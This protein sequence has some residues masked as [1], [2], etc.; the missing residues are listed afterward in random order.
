VEA[1]TFS[2]VAGSFGPVA[3]TAWITA[4]DDTRGRPFIIVDKLSARVLV[5]DGAGG[6][7][8]ETAALIGVAIRDDSPPG[9]GMMRLADIAPALR[10]TPA[11]RFEAHLGQNLKG[12]GIL[13][14]DYE[15][16]L[17]LHPVATGNPAE[18]RLQRLTTGDIADNRITYGCI[19]VPSRFYEDVVQPL[20]APA[21][22]IVYILPELSS[23]SGGRQSIE[24]PQE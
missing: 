6:L 8:G 22:G 17:S 3:L 1:A 23:P 7:V 24:A 2:T 10:V 18:R 13:W 16:A 15:A 20:F 14:V 19:N 4:T 11:G 5:F 9:I 12:G 21:N